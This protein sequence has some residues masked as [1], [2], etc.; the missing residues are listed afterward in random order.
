MVKIVNANTGEVIIETQ[1]VGAVAPQVGDFML[2]NSV[3]YLVKKRLFGPQE[4]TYFVSPVPT[5][6]ESGL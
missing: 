5:K 6:N 2:F 3:E 4:L 1:A